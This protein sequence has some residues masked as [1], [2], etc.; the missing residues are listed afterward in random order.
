MS[1][2]SFSL[3]NLFQ[4]T[5]VV[6][7]GNVIGAG[8]AFL[9][10]V[11]SGQYLS[12]DGY[13]KLVLALSVFNIVSIFTL[14]GLPR[15]LAKMI[16]NIENKRSRVFS[17][18]LF[19]LVVSGLVSVV[20]IVILREFPGVVPF[21]VP[22]SIMTVFL[23]SIPLNIG[24]RVLIGGF[25]GLGLARYQLILQNIV[26]QFGVTLLIICAVLIG[27]DIVGLSLSWPI[28]LGFGLLLAGIAFYRE[29]ANEP[30]ETIGPRSGIQ[31][32]GS[33]LIFSLPLML[34]DSLWLLTQY[35]DNLLVGFFRGN[36]EL[37]GYDAA[38]SLSRLLLQPL[39]AFAFLALP[40]FSRFH[41]E[42]RI[43]EIRQYYSLIAKW[44]VFVTLPLFLFL[45]SFPELVISITFGDE[46]RF[47]AIVL[48]IVASGFFFHVL[49]GLN[50]RLLTASGDT[51]KI[52]YGNV[53]ALTANLILNVLLIPIF[54]IVGAAIAS[55]STYVVANAYWTALVYRKF[56]VQPLSK[57]YVFPVFVSLIGYV[58]VFQ[59]S[60]LIFDRTGF[61]IVSIV[62]VF[63]FLHLGSIVG[64]GL[65]EE[66]RE[67]IENALS[68][69][70]SL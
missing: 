46:F 40:L 12:V 33:L 49:V 37:G 5:T 29:T 48:T 22:S 60:G 42:N 58:S 1:D 50:N 68:R 9:M 17:V 41:S 20:S 52:L 62:I 44:L 32:I 3:G 25:R 65:E 53:F 6:F 36:T 43:A 55:A 18:L 56:G 31:W 61:R 23:I 54:G 27:V 14:M 63:G 34:S 57:K 47:G 26:Y 28:A 15:G 8:S 4:S 11:I 39:T 16:P 69:F 24:L 30:T 51:Y 45:V 38:F 59:V 10:R 66:D 19:S 70:V 2:E 13:G 7:L 35:L 21:D 64:L 67:M